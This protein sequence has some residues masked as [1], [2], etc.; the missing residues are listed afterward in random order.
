MKR[1]GIAGAIGLVVMGGSLLAQLSQSGGSAISGPVTVAQRSACGTT[2]FDSGILTL[3]VT[4]ATVTTTA[5]CVEAVVFIN[6]TSSTQA[7]TFTDNQTT[8][9]AYLA[10]F[11]I[12]ANSTLVYNLHH[13][14]LAGGIR[15]QAANASA[16]N[17]QIVGFQ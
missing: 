16:V 13:A 15:W 4:A 8:P 5:T 17:A 2:P 12:P 7:V 3:P 9:V 11:Q 1:V 10:N 6:A 14:R